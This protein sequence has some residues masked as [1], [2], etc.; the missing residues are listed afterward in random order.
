MSNPEGIS[1]TLK[2]VTK[3]NPGL[4]FV[5][6]DFGTGY[7]SLSYLSTLPV[8]LLKIDLSFVQGL[9]RVRNRKIVTTS[10]SLDS[11]EAACSDPE[12]GH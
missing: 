4:R 2:K 1:E 7:S 6:D 12:S 9:D 8:D 3:R 11:Y 10:L 5:I